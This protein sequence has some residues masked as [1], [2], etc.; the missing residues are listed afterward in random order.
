[1]LD[2]A[3]AG[4]RDGEVN[5]NDCSDLMRRGAEVTMD[6]CFILR[7]MRWICRRFVLQI[8]RWGC[9]RSKT[10]LLVKKEYIL[11]TKI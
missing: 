11:L 2:R 5:G 10:G 8:G 4:S 1:M 7:E 6:I 9:V 3:V